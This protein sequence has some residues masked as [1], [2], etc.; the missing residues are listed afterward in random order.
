MAQLREQGLESLE[1]VKLAR[2][3][4]D[5][6]ISVTPRKAEKRPTKRRGPAS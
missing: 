2:M 1:D 3:E 5:G 4:G 6:R